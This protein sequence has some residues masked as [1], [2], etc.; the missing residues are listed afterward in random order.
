MQWKMTILHIINKQGK[1]REIRVNK[2]LLKYIIAY[3]NAKYFFDS[4]FQ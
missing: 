4:I 2:S 3:N 1:L